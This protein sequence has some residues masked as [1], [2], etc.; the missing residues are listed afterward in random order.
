MASWKI[1]EGD[2]HDGARS[3]AFTDAHAE[4]LGVE[5]KSYTFRVES[6]GEVIAGVTAWSMGPDLHVDMLGVEGSHRR[7]GLGSALLAHVEEAGRADGC[8]TAS[9][10]TFS[11]QAPD[12]YPRHGYREIFRYPLTDGTERIYFTKSL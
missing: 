10:D 5:F 1:V 3:G 4:A 11:F 8:T 2:T 7:E 9:V 6:D 12:F